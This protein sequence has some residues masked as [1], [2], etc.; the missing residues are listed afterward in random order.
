MD[1]LYA[2]VD[3]LSLFAPGTGPF[4]SFWPTSQISL[5]DALKQP[6]DR[7]HLII[8]QDKGTSVAGGS[9]T[10]SFAIQRIR[11]VLSVPL[12]CLFSPQAA[13]DR[14]GTKFEQ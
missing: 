1:T 7:R 12:S 5:K 13:M 8:W 6:E 3:V 14:I 2:W 4:W 10:P 11:C 9:K